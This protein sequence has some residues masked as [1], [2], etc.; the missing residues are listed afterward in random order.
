MLGK[1]EDVN[2]VYSRDKISCPV[3]IHEEIYTTVSEYHNHVGHHG[4]E[5][6]PQ[7]LWMPY[8]VVIISLNCLSPVVHLI[9]TSIT[10]TTSKIP[11][12]VATEQTSR[13]DFDM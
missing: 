8:E 4:Y 9:N 1:V 11:Y 10:E 7:Y 12:E 2:V 3:V 13:S 6:K 5:V